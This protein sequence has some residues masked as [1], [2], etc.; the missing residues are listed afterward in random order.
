[1]AGGE[2]GIGK[3][4]LWIQGVARA[5]AHSYRALCARPAEPEA[6]FAFPALAELLQPVVDVL[7]DRLPGPRRRALRIA[8]LLEEAPHSPPDPTAIAFD[9]ANALVAL[10]AEAPVLIAI[11]DW[12][13]P[14]AG[15]LEFAAR[16]LEGPR[17]C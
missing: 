16:R 15:V 10:A 13:R 6:R 9:F 7:E 8:L 11:D 12:I 5:Q 1:M 17:H 3:S 4:T 2:A 14:R